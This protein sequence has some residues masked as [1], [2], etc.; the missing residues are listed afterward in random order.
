MDQ[1]AGPVRYPSRVYQ[2]FVLRPEI[3]PRT[4][5]LDE[6]IRRAHHFRIVAVTAPQG[7]G[8][9]QLMRLLANVLLAH[10]KPVHVITGWPQDGIQGGW[11]NYLISQTGYNGNYWLSY[12]AYL[13]LDEAQHTYWDQDFHERFFAKIQ[14]ESAP[15]VILFASHGLE[16]ILGDLNSIQSFTP[17]GKG[18]GL[19]WD[20]PQSPCRSVGL[21]FRRYEADNF[22][23][24]YHFARSSPAPTD[25][26]K[27]GF[28]Q[29]TNGN[30]GMLTALLDILFYWRGF[31][32]KPNSFQWPIVTQALFIDLPALFQ[33][34]HDGL[35]IRTGLGLPHSNDLATT[36]ELLDLAVASNGLYLDRLDP[37]SKQ[38]LSLIWRY[39]WLLPQNSKFGLRFV[40]ASPMHRWYFY[41]M[42]HP[43]WES[44]QEGLLHRVSQ[45]LRA[46]QFTAHITW[47]HHY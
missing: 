18:I 46:G 12:E 39:G 11:E 27:E 10:T 26:M 28:F 36:W 24:R 29:C 43:L 40:F 20:I 45:A 3:L 37:D 7:S 16:P 34:M 32:N 23:A 41:H 35:G 5:I 14:P 17:T 21:L 38:I 44:G 22:I 8:K 9:T 47:K 33:T 42:L 1:Q 2:P 6:L 31:V 4:D 30:I 13:L 19:H 25:E 15:C